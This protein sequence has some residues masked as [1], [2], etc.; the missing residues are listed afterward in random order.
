MAEGSKRSFVIAELVST[1]GTYI[2][3]LE[4]IIY[5]YKQPAQAADFGL[6]PSFIDTVFSNIEDIHY[7]AYYFHQSLEVSL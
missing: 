6:D 7:T 1:E 4:L 3:D 2:D 5:D